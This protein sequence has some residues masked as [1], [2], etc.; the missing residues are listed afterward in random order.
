M[1]IA[2]V[3]RQR[4]GNDDDDVGGD[5][6]ERTPCFFKR[7]SPLASFPATPAAGTESCLSPLSR[8]L[9]FR[10]FR[11]RRKRLRP[12]STGELKPLPLATDVGAVERVD[13]GKRLPDVD[14]DSGFKH[15][16]M[17]FNLGMGFGLAFLLA[18]NAL[19]MKKMMELRKQMETLLK[20]IKYE[21]QRRYD[22]SPCTTSDG[23]EGALS[24]I[25]S[26]RQHSSSLDME[27]PRNFTESNIQKYQST[28][29]TSL[30]KMEAEL[31]FELEQMQLNLEGLEFGQHM[32]ESNNKEVDA[33]SEGSP[34]A[35]YDNISKEKSEENN[36]I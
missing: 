5:V 29:F 12:D 14:S 19:E 9:L 20:E 10:W 25:T 16:Q 35:W 4:D 30:N 11:Q 8:S 32:V 36:G 33:S 13:S 2:D 21:A 26:M 28:Y 23:G 3:L 7:T 15:N 27:E 1:R 18:G 34:P 31:H 24:T 17:A 22:S 6:R